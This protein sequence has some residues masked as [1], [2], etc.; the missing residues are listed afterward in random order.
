VSAFVLAN[1]GLVATQAA[2]VAPPLLLAWCRVGDLDVLFLAF[3]T[4][5]ATVPVAAAL[6]L[7]GVALRRAR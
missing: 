7:R 3:S 2:L 4:L 1:A 6:L 5:P